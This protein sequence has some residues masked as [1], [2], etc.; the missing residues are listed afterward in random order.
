MS[1][2][3]HLL[4]TGPQLYAWATSTGTTIDVASIDPAMKASA[5]RQG[6]AAIGV[7]VGKAGDL[8]AVVQK[9]SLSTNV[10]YKAVPVGTYLPGRFTKFLSSGTVFDAAVALVAKTTTFAGGGGPADLAA[11]VTAINTAC[12]ATVAAADASGKYLVLTP[13]A[14]DGSLTITGGTGLALLL[15]LPATGASQY[16]TLTMTGTGN[17]SGS[18]AA[19]AG[20]YFRFLSG[21]TIKTV[22]FATTPANLAAVVALVNAQAAATGAAST[23]YLK[24]TGP[25][26][27]I[28]DG[29]ALS[30]LGFVAGQVGAASGEP[31]YTIG[32]NQGPSALKLPVTGTVDLT[33]AANLTALTST[34]LILGVATGISVASTAAELAIV[35][36]P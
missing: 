7:Y 20:T 13:H 19:L 11:I 33:V 21:N 30:T 6:R 9:G 23:N 14:G 12:S 2:L 29:S 24:L 15:G 10:F 36:E 35:W 32:L 31:T 4:R 26:L 27:T 34:T 18:L 5:P 1:N 8:A 28:I 25:Q 16:P 17:L 22:T 3:N